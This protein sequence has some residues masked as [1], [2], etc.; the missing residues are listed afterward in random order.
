ME[1]E[2]IEKEMRP[3]LSVIIPAYNEEM[4]IGKT[5]DSVYAYL[6]EQPFTWELLIVLDGVTDGTLGVVQ[7][8]AQGKKNLRWIDRKENRGKGFT[9]RQGMLA[10]KGEIRLFTDAD[11]STEM[12]HFDKM[13]PFFKSGASVVICSRDAKDAEGANQVI[14]QPFL[15]RF[16]GN[17]GNLFIQIV[18]V[19]GIWDTQ[20][21]FKAFRAAAAEKIF[22]ISR[23]ERW[24]FDMEA[25]ALA[26]RFGYKIEVVG[27][28]WVD[29]PNTH[30]TKLDYIR[31]LTEAVKV[32]W[33]LLTGGYNFATAET[34]DPRPAPVEEL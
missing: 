2:K 24:G 29:E 20:C 7:N 8:F 11:N 17:L 13:K 22:T 10:A 3:Y 14:P 26:R 32:R 31:S 23:I 4:R 9:I 1:Q 21:G 19:P 15:K 5:L 28:N 25:L 27:A 12:S 6:L 33:H 18:A 34:T 16:L 30:V